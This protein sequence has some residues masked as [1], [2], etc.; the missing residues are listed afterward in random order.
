MKSEAGS[1]PAPLFDS[2]SF[3]PSPKSKIREYQAGDN[4]NRAWKSTLS[5]HFEK[6]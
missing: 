3:S 4:L 6:I 2:N 1:K 5:S